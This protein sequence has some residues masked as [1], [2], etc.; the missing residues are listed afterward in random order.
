MEKISKPG[1]PGRFPALFAGDI[2]I[3]NEYGPTEAT[4]G[5]M[6]YRFDPERDHQ[7]SVAI[8]KP[9]DNLRIYLLDSG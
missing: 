6:I 4:I 8:G 1:W 3:Y 7:P 2:V 5:C 9:I